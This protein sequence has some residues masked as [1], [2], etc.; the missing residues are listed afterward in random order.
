MTNFESTP[1][2]VLRQTTALSDDTLPADSDSVIPPEGHESP[3]DNLQG[4]IP[5][6]P[7][8]AFNSVKIELGF[9][10]LIGVVLWLAAD[11][12]TADEG[13]QWLLLMSYG[14]SSMCWLILRTRAIL[15]QCT[16]MK[17]THET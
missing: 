10:M 12:I 13:T 8:S 15:R 9:A 16:A 11:S 6:K 5:D 14:L 7:F 17:G 4:N 1:K 2:Q 3:P